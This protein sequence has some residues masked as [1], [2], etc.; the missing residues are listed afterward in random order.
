MT[1][2]RDLTSKRRKWAGKEEYDSK[3]AQDELIQRFKLSKQKLK[4]TVNLELSSSDSNSEFNPD[5]SELM[6]R[7]QILEREKK[8]LEERNLML[9]VRIKQ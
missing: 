4:Q 3:Y 9:Q 5:N 6:K 1:S 7:V 2:E 8:K